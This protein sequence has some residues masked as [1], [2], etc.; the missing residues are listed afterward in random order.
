M[1]EVMFVASLDD[2][3]EEDVDVVLRVG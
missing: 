1:A 3:D 2:D